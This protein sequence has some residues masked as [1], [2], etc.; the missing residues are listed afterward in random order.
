MILKE[1]A[2]T[3]DR[4]HAGEFRLASSMM[5]GWA[6]MLCVVHI[7]VGFETDFASIPRFLRFVFSVNGKHRL[8]AVLHD[9]LYRSG[10]VI[11]VD[12][13]FIDGV[14]AATVE[15]VE[16]RYTRKDADD[17]FY[18]DMLAAGVGRLQAYSMYQGVR[19]FGWLF[20]NKCQKCKHG[21]QHSHER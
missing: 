4:K 14:V 9:F 10:G 3:V 11:R 2:F 15:T 21:N 8:S 16:V 17:E 7:P 5:Y 13:S 12:A 6:L 1:P 18:R 19:A 20:W